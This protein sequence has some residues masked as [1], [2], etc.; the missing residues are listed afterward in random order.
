[1]VKPEYV[2]GSEAS[3]NFISLGRALFQAPETVLTKKPAKA[4]KKAIRRKPSGKDKA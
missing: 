1:V 3:Q 2:E 4:A